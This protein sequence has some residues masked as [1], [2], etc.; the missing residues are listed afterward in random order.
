[1]IM[2]KAKSSV[3]IHSPEPDNSIMA[4]YRQLIDLSSDAFFLVDQ[5]L[6]VLE[7]S[8]KTAFFIGQPREELYGK[9]MIE[10]LPHLKDTE[11]LER[12][13]QV[14][15]D[16][17]PYSYEHYWDHPILKKMAFTVK[18]FKI[19]EFMGV[20]VRDISESL[21]LKNNLINS[22]NQLD[23]AGIYIDISERIEMKQLLQDRTNKLNILYKIILAGN[24]SQN[25]NDLCKSIVDETVK[26]LSFDGGTLHLMEEG[27][28]NLK[29]ARGFNYHYLGSI[30]QVKITPELHKFFFESGNMM[31]TENFSEIDPKWAKKIQTETLVTIPLQTKEKVLGF[32]KFFYKKART[33]GKEEQSLLK[34]IGQ[35]ASTVLAKFLT[36][37]EIEKSLREKEVLLQEIQHRVKNNLQIISGLITLNREYIQDVKALATFDD[38]QGRIKSM[39]LIHDILYKTPNFET[40]SFDLYLN[41]L[42]NS[43][44]YSISSKP[45]DIQIEYEVCQCPLEIKQAIN[46]GLI[47]NELVSNAIKHGFNNWEGEKKIFINLKEQSSKFILTIQD[48]GKGLP[49]DFSK[50]LGH[51]MGLSLCNTLTDQLKGEISLDKNPE[52]IAGTKITITFPKTKSFTGI[53]YKSGIIPKK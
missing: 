31:I 20:I 17:Q 11:K 23:L 16:G 50:D 47:V 32:L 22:E 45:S 51:S 48:S 3:D 6:K 52:T 43:V 40:I 15:Q 33:I 35:H 26:S 27:I 44:V 36:Q 2:Q 9:E 30:Q 19:G 1:M 53:P 41:R 8:A 18:A 25:F 14:F 42:V 7:L 38:F 46:C 13:R 10:L 39:A 34:S 5:D 28:F 21:N 37:I 24:T 49:R 12:F 4:A 29:Y